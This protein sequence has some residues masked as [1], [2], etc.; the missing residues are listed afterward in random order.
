VP[1]PYFLK[2]VVVCSKILEIRK[3]VPGISE[4]EERTE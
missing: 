4:N 2:A 1:E 3:M